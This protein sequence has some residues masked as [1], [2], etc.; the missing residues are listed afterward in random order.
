MCF[1]SDVH[2]IQLL[3]PL[4]QL[5]VE[6]FPGHTSQSEGD[7]QCL[8]RVGTG[9]HEKKLLIN[10]WPKSWFKHYPSANP[11]TL[12]SQLVQP[13]SNND[14]AGACVNC[15]LVPT[16]VSVRD[17]SIVHVP[18]LPNTQDF[19]KCCYIIISIS[20]ANSIQLIQWN[21]HPQELKLAF[22]RANS[23]QQTCLNSMSALLI[24]L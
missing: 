23:F 19:L 24:Y 14:K 10:Q 5:I 13:Y 3:L 16:S 17:S 8:I 6:Q 2:Y 7:S 21:A 11:G 22:L 20:N 9:L 18:G 1:A 15:S 4:L 12:I